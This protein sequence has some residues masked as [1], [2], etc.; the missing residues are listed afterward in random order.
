[1]ERGC[2]LLVLVVL[3]LHRAL[4]SCRSLWISEGESLVSW[5]WCWGPAHGWSVECRQQ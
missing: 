4:A 3:L 2:W 1:V 5:W